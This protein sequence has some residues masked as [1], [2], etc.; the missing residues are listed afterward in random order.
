[1]LG[2]D[3][4]WMAWDE[5]CLVEYLISLRLIKFLKDFNSTLL[6]VKCYN[7]LKYFNTFTKFAIKSCYII[8]KVFLNFLFV[9]EKIKNENS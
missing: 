7:C 2:V 9:K 5:W 3:S 8:L 4:W 6:R 1:M